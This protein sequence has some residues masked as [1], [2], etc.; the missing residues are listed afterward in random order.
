M[1][2]DRPRLSYTELRRRADAYQQMVQ[3]RIDR[4]LREA[5]L[6]PAQITRHA[7]G[8]CY[9][10][11]ALPSDPVRKAK[12]CLAR[13]LANNRLYAA[14]VKIAVLVVKGRTD[15]K[16]TQPMAAP[17]TTGL[18]APRVGRRPFTKEVST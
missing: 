6:D 5:G 11:G 1:K 16:R 4:L 7:N 3:A 10:H 2:T 13:K 17:K 8:R 18:D 9:I 12:V 14:H 15:L